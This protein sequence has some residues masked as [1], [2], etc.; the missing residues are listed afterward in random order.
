MKK[1]V[2]LP[3]KNEEWIIDTF[4]KNVTRWADLV[5]IAD[6]YSTDSTREIIKTYQNVQVI[7]NSYIGHSNKVRW[8]LRDTLIEK[9]RTLSSNNINT[10]TE[11]STKALVFCLDADELL[12]EQAL[13][14]TE[15]EVQKNIDANLPVHTMRFIYPWFQMYSSYSEARIDGVWEKSAQMAGFVIDLTKDIPDYARSEIINDHTT[16]IPTVYNT[17]TPITNT[18][19]TT[20]LLCPHPLLHLQFLATKRTQL[21]QAWYMCQELLSQKKDVRRIN[22][23]YADAIHFRDIKLKKVNPAYVQ[24]LELPNTSS[25][26]QVDSFRLADIIN[27]FTLHGI[28]T[29]EP[30]DIWHISVLKELFIKEI[31]RN[32]RSNTYPTYVRIAHTYMPQTLKNMIKWLLK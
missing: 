21:K 18:Q 25:L 20:P 13:H 31:G 3:V 30:L 2:L 29:F 1:I 8:L 5:I 27:L 16:R 14:W 7:D 4:L 32:P 10:D 9:L 24:N 26:T 19:S 28:Q 17:E 6:Q 11:L 15:A 23:Q 22:L 12:T